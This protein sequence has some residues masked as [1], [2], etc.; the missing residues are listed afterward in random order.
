[1]HIINKY[2]FQNNTERKKKL[3]NNTQY[4]YIYVK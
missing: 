1:M 4:I 2:P 3:I